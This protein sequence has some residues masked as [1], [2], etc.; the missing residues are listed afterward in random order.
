MPLVFGEVAALY[1]DVRPGYPGELRRAIEGRAPAGPAVDIGAGT[2]KG[3]EVLA[4]IRDDVTAIEPDARMAAVL[5]SKFP[6]VDVVE[7]TFEQWAPPPGGV[8]LLACAMAWHWM[9]ADTRNQQAADAL[10]PSGVLAVFG[11]RF[12]YADRGQSA[13]I[14][15]VFDRANRDVKMRPVHWIVDDVRGSGVWSSV[16]ELEWHRDLPLGT[17][18]Y[19]AL[20]QTFSPFRRHSPELQ[21]RV[22]DDLRATI[23]GFGGT[24]TLDLHTTLVM[25]Q[26]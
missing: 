3:T 13:A 23:D 8:G 7:T 11:H 21:R 19:L 5:R 22:L 6:A 12:G 2:G 26:R 9:D 14:G 20:T 17:E 16:D 4:A 15:A 1:D 24:I 25:A 18:G 10:S